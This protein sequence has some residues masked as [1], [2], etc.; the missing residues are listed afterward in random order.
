MDKKYKCCCSQHYDCI[1]HCICNK[2]CTCSSHRP[3]YNYGSIVET[4]I[5][6][7][8][9]EKRTMKEIQDIIYKKNCIRYK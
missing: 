7:Q 1:V 2:S 9:I 8:N 5:L 6:I 3:D 4:K